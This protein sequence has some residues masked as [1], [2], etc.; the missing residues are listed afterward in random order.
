MNKPTAEQARKLE[1]DAVVAWLGD[2]NGQHDV[3]RFLQLPHADV[4]KVMK[5][6]ATGISAVVHKD[7]LDGEA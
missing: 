2:L 4:A 7:Y 3:S 5:M 6:C 1:R